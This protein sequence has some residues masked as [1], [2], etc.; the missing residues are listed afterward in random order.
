MYRFQLFS[1][2]CAVAV[3]IVMCS[4]HVT[5]QL[6]SPDD[7]AARKLHDLFELRDQWEREHFP[8]WAMSRGDYSNADRLADTSLEAIEQ[9]HRDTIAHR[10][11]LHA[12][13]PA[14]LSPTDQINHNLFDLILT[15]DI[16]GHEF[17]TFLSPIGGRFGPQQSIPQMAERVRFNS[18]EDYQN[19]LSRLEQVP[20]MVQALI[21]RMKVGVKEGRTPPKVTLEGV[22]AQFDA[23]LESDGGLTLLA[24]PFERIP[25][26]IDEEVADGIRSRFETWSLPSVRSSIAAMREFFVNDYLPHCRTS[27]AA[28]DYPDGENYYKH[29]LFVMT[30][31]EISAQQVHEIGLSEVKRIR[32]EMMDVIRSSDF[33]ELRP[34]AS[35][36]SDDDL[37]AAFVEYL[38]TDPRFYY[39]KPED[40]LDGYRVICKKVDPWMARLFKTLPRQPYGVKEIPA[41]M[42]PNQTTAYYSGGDMRNAEPGYFYA[43]TYALDQRPKYEMTALAIHEA[44]PGHHHQVAIATEMEDVPEFRR[45]TWITAY[46]EGWAL[47]SERLGMEM[48]LYETPY[49][50]FGRLL[51]EM[52]RACRLVVDPGM[53]ALGWSRQQAIDFMA[54]N[55]ALSMLNIQ[56]EVDRY[57]AWPGQATA[58]KLGELKIRE[59]RTQAES[60]LGE[61]FDIREFHDVILIDGP[62][63]LP[64]LDDKVNAWIA[65]VQAQVRD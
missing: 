31:L 65:D 19:Y 38:R 58:Y 23:L 48:G 46:G 49:D 40:L 1:L 41:F 52:W 24:E 45:N 27:I 11:M 30:T 28:A 59:L 15:R 50:N 44:V 42:A 35:S 53:H 5:A 51:Y 14:Q 18:F 10:E 22:P 36:L 25:K 32:A 7:V 20:Q 47:Y 39:D 34:E 21:E 60:E 29:Q 4:D 64:M 33:M 61:H 56:T 8:S 6:T 62:M 9:R 26:T 12:I 43:N 57:I 16:R 63:T 3:S 37:F 17:R 13:S 2:A 55:T 54:A